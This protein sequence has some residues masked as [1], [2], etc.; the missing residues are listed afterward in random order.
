[1]QYFFLSLC[2]LLPL[3]HVQAQEYLLEN[4][5]CQITKK[6]QCLNDQRAK[7]IERIWR[8][9]WSAGKYIIASIK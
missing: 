8:I 7:S 6:K 5:K 9:F 2:G 3:F 1:M 4:N